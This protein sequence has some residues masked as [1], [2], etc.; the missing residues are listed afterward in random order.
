VKVAPTTTPRCPA[1]QGEDVRFVPDSPVEEDGFE[2][3][4]PPAKKDPPRQ[5][6]RPF[7]HFPSER[8]RGF[9]SVFLQERVACEPQDDSL[10]RGIA[11]LESPAPAGISEILRILSPK[12][13]GVRED[14]QSGRGEVLGRI[15]L[16]A[17]GA[18]AACAAARNA[19]AAAT[20]RASA[21]AESRRGSPLAS[22][23]AHRD[24]PVICNSGSA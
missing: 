7:Q 16:A 5:D 3:S 18:K 22:G 8:D 24:R 19:E 15:F 6:V 14:H 13:V 4:V 2:P 10:G 20:A 9:E 11:G 17:R 1:L 21:P 12:T 23:C